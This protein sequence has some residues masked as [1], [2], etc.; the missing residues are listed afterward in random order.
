MLRSNAKMNESSSKLMESVDTILSKF[1]GKSDDDGLDFNDIM[2]RRVMN[3]AHPKDML[4]MDLDD[5]TKEVPSV[6]L[7]SDTL[8]VIKKMRER[9]TKNG[10]EHHDD[11]DID[12]NN[13]AS[14][15]EASNYARN[16]DKTCSSNPYHAVKPDAQNKKLK[17]YKSFVLT[18]HKNKIKTLVKDEFDR[19]PLESP[20]V[21]DVKEIKLEREDH[22]KLQ[23]SS[24]QSSKDLAEKQNTLTLQ[25]RLVTQGKRWKCMICGKENEKDK[26][27]CTVCGRQFGYK[28]ILDKTKKEKAQKYGRNRTETDD[29]EKSKGS[30]QAEIL[31][32]LQ[33]KVKSEKKRSLYMNQKVDYECHSRG[34]LVDDISDLLSS[35]RESRIDN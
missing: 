17:T 19:T 11:A 15:D 12:S 29:K 5:K 31:D 26:Y 1:N 7:V 35:L 25:K 3:R 27:L 33:K 9:L 2:T 18:P 14:G 4:M 28:G 30:N 23:R 20:S 13:N 10:H 8:R 22:D 24:D 21:N 32:N 34:A 6:L 16:N